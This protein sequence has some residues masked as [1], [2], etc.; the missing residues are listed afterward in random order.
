M[1]TRRR[2]RKR[3]RIRWDRILVA[4]LLVAAL[5]YG[6]SRLL[7]KD[8]GK[9]PANSGSSS[10][11][12]GSAPA[13]SAP[14][15][16]APAG[17]ESAPAASDPESQAPSS[18]PEPTPEELYYQQLVETASVN[19]TKD[20]PQVT[21]PATWN[22][23]AHRLIAQL[24]GRENYDFSV[25]EGYDYLIMVNRAAS[26][27]T[28]YTA[29]ED[30]KY[31]VPFM[32]MVCSGGDDTPTGFFDTPINY[33][34]RLLAGPSYGQY[35]TR[36]WS[37]YLFHSVPYYTQHKDDVEYDQFNQ[38]GT[39]ASLGCIRLMIVDVKWIYDNCPIGTP[40]VIYDD[41]ENPGPMGKPGTIYTDPADKDKRGWDP[42]DPDSANPWDEQFRSGT[43]IRSE[44]AQKQYDA[45]VKN[46]TWRDSITPCDLQGFSTDSSTEGT[47]G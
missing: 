21:D 31:S 7:N 45:A 19:C 1:A 18:E 28:V 12:S 41:A 10:V 16:S 11:P 15:G 46:G 27:V 42:T 6:C 13:S 14:S 26:T 34:W 44:A 47:R 17:S 29:G 23:A 38:L 30:K 2:R 20:Q 39:P 33:S 43:T 36:I 25:R 24:E 37:S 8:G 9:D 35:A 5:G 3:T 32:A 4:L 22:A 40:V